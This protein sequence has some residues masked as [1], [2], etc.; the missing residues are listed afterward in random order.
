MKTQTNNSVIDI[1]R[2]TDTPKAF[3]SGQG[4]GMRMKSILPYTNFV[5]NMLVRDAEI[6][7]GEALLPDKGRPVIAIASHGPGFAWVP[8]PALTG[9]VFMENGCGEVIGGMYPHKAMLL[10]PGLKKYYKKILGAP[11]EIKTVADIV[12]VLKKNEIGF[13]GISKRIAF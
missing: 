9:K 2:F 12:S 13:G 8:L 11:T 6:I 5:L 1:S 10:I 3:V 4:K 7:N